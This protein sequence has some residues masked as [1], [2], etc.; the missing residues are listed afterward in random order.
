M[1][2]AGGTNPS[3]YTRAIHELLSKVKSK[4]NG[5][6]DPSD[7]MSL[8]EYT[9]YYSS[10]PWWS[11]RY[12]ASWEG[13]LAVISLPTNSPANS[14]SV[15]K[16]IDGDIFRRVRDDGELGEKL[17]F[18]RDD[19]GKIYRVSQHGNFSTRIQK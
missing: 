7:E 8:E 12:I 9:G 14:M 13:Q 11:E 6:N 2:N 15:F 5:D 1:I 18:E 19:T 16:H 10:Q 17:I 4:S 3:K